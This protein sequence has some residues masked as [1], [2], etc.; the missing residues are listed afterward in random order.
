MW[1]PKLK[2]LLFSTEHYQWSLL[3]LNRRS[4][5]W[6]PRPCKSNAYKTYLSMRTEAEFTPNGISNSLSQGTKELTCK[7][8]GR[9]TWFPVGTC[10]SC[11]LEKFRC[12]NTCTLPL[13][14]IPLWGKHSPRQDFLP[15]LDIKKVIVAAALCPSTEEPILEKS[16]LLF[17]WPRGVFLHHGLT[18]PSPL[19]ASVPGLWNFPCEWGKAHGFPIC[20]FRWQLGNY[21]LLRVLLEGDD[22]FT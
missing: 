17:S 3:T 2:F 18:I 9:S 8:L 6:T 20:N 16:P 10:R 11:C 4:T 14:N 15:C 22:G 12:M 5:F 19:P 7:G 21:C 1:T 13:Q